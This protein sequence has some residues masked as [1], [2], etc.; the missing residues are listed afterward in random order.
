MIPPC[1]LWLWQASLDERWR[2][3][4]ARCW[5]DGGDAPVEPPSRSSTGTAPAGG[6]GGGEEQGKGKG[7]GKATTI[8]IIEPKEKKK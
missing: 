1:L 4:D 3:G 8:Y 7:K 5:E 6:G 2:T